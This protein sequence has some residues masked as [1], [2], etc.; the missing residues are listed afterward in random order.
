MPTRII[1]HYCTCDRGHCKQ[2]G[3]YMSIEL[4]VCS[5]ICWCAPSAAFILSVLGATFE[6]YVS[7]IYLCHFIIRLSKSQTHKEAKAFWKQ[8]QE[9]LKDFA[10]ILFVFIFRH[11]R[12]VSLI[13]SMHGYPFFN[14][15]QFGE[16]IK[17]KMK[18]KPSLKK[19][20][21][22][23]GDGDEVFIISWLLNIRRPGQTTVSI[24]H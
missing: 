21:M 11:V 18:K 20:M 3:T 15:L 5:A 22:A 9:E 14:S 16:L 4:Y 13:S 24:A 8:K 12:A 1:F 6:Y 19:L 17:Q 2:I 7:N 10:N 23:G